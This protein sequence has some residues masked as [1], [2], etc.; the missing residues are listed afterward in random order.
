MNITDDDLLLVTGATGLVGSH[1][2]EQARQQGFR[3]RALVR[4][5]SDTKLLDEWGVEK[6]VGD[7]TD[8]ESLKAAVDGV[9][10]IVHCAAKVGDWGPVGDY[11]TVNVQGLER[12]LIEA[13]QTGLLK[14]YIHISS[15]G[16]YQARDHYGTDE[17]EQPNTRGIDGYTLT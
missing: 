3:T 17:S 10:L 14:R 8:S 5:S 13:E 1:V 9:T 4:E 7:L 2:V 16:V 6:V 15:L 12:L 11:R